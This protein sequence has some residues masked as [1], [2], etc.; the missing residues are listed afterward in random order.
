M[1]KND[2]RNIQNM[3]QKIMSSEIHIFFLILEQKM[4]FDA[5]KMDGF[6]DFS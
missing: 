4:Y 3:N 2:P 6:I 5:Q 1:N